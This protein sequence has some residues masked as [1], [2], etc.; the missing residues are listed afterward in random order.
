MRMARQGRLCDLLVVVT[1]ALARKPVDDAVGPSETNIVARVIRFGDKVDGLRE[2]EL[3][4][5]R[6]APRRRNIDVEERNYPKIAF[7]GPVQPDNELFEKGRIVGRVFAARTRS[8]DSHG[9][10]EA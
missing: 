10:T 5:R 7:A 9:L 8:E 2:G 1:K 3:R 4:R 6:T